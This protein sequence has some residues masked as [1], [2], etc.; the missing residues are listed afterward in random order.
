MFLENLASHK[1]CKGSAD[2]GKYDCQYN[3]HR[4]VKCKWSQKSRNR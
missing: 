2:C 3:I 1:S 4:V